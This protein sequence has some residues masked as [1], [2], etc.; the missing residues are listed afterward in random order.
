MTTH[1]HDKFT[2]NI[3]STVENNPLWGI[4]SQSVKIV[5]QKF[6]YKE[7]TQ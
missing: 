7:A 2:Q 6:I 3:L 5:P 4:R 1:Q